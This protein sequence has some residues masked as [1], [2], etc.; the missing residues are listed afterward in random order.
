MLQ[1]PS[2]KQ[3]TQPQ[4][5]SGTLAIEKLQIKVAPGITVKCEPCPPTEGSTW[6]RAKCWVP[7]EKDSHP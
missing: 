3:A 6:T 4:L 1:A 5:S 7:R 2:L